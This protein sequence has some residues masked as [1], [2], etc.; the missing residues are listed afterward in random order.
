M[1]IDCKIKNN[2]YRATSFSPK[3]HTDE[4]INNVKKKEN[5]MRLHT[6][7]EKCKVIGKK[8]F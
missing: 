4:E 8:E 2:A 6:H 3:F 7:T 5:S 1:R